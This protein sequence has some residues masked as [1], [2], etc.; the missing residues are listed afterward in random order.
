MGCFPARDEN[1]R[2]LSHAD[3][4]ALDA[5]AADAAEDF[6]AAIQVAVQDLANARRGPRIAR[7]WHALR[8]QL[9]GDLGEPEAVAG[10][11]EDP[12]NDRRLPIVE[13]RDV[14][15]SSS[16]TFQFL[17]DGDERTSRVT[18][19]TNFGR[20]ITV[21]EHGTQRSGFETCYSTYKFE[22]ELL[23]AVT[24]G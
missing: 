7:G 10:H 4:S 9:V 5:V 18:A 22:N 23:A 12:T 20:I 1:Q 15:G 19:T 2:R 8:V 14:L 17:V 24:V 3:L 13:L 11:L 6:D 16:A 21:S